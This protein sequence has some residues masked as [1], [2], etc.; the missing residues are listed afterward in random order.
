MFA[1]TCHQNTNI[2]VWVLVWRDLC[3]P[4]SPQEQYE[5][6]CEMGSTFQL[7]KICAE[8]DKDVKI[9]P[10]GHLMCTS[11]LTAW[12]VHPL[13]PPFR[14]VYFTQARMVFVSRYYRSRGALE[15]DPSHGYVFWLWGFDVHGESYQQVSMYS[16]VKLHWTAKAEMKGGWGCATHCGINLLAEKH[17]IIPHVLP[18]Q[19]CTTLT[20]TNTFLDSIYILHQ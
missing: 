3:T 17:N 19:H 7:C 10:C 12:Q 11:C 6:Y 14:V 1:H 2:C 20:S 4:F 9:E 5:L 13:S 16:E 8:N 15:L 18:F